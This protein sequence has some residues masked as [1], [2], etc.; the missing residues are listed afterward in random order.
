VLAKSRRNP[1]SEE[2][3]AGRRERLDR[4]AGGNAPKRKSAGGKEAHVMP[5]KKDQVEKGSKQ[6]KKVGKNGVHRG[7]GSVGEG[8]QRRRLINSGNTGKARP[9]RKVY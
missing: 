8:R 5:L 6:Q 2:E 1:A 9:A 3:Q 7:S 4:S